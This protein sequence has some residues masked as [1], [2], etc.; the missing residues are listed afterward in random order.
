MGWSLA[1]AGPQLNPGGNMETPEI[2]GRVHLITPV[3]CPTCGNTM[4]QTI[5]VPGTTIVRCGGC[6]AFLRLGIKATVEV[7]VVDNPDAQSENQA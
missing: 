1:A 5:S 3:L 6:G 2:Y 4:Q 7:G